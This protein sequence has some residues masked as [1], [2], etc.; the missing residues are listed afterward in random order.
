MDSEG[1]QQQ[2]SSQKRSQKHNY[3]EDD[4]QKAM[5][6]CSLDGPGRTTL[7]EASKRFGVPISTISAR[8]HGRKDRRSAH[9]HQQLLTKEQEATLARICQNRG[10]RG[11]PISLVELRGLAGAIN[12]KLPG[13]SW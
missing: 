1:S 5:E 3:S 11:D 7:K 6:S 9:E 13:P 2:K 8:L 4:L 10:Y 12:G